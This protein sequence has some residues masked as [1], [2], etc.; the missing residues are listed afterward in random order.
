VCRTCGCEARG[1][2]FVAPREKGPIVVDV[3]EVPAPILEENEAAAARIRARLREAGVLA[4]NILGTPGGGKTALLEATLPRLAGRAAVV[5]AD[6]ATDNDARRIRRAGGVEVIPVE[7]G[8]TCHLSAP[9]LERAI[10]R[11]PLGEI[12]TLFV[13][14]VG[15]LV[16]PALFDVGEAA[17]VVILS[18]TEGDDKPEKY[19]VM[20]QHASLFIVNKMD[21]L[22][23]CDFD[24]AR[25]AAFARRV[26]PEIEVL[27]TSARKG[28][29]IDAWLAWLERLR[30]R[31]VPRKAAGA[32]AP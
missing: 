30:E 25:A 20:F 22:P 8:T 9:M 13:E 26:H 7:T 23:H 10:A 6:L 28:E 29:G 11:V 27:T 4:V 31:I 21:M 19:P 32:G 14:N 17:K 15:N 5:V 16:C 2:P 18:V 3:I 24:V 12:D 1:A